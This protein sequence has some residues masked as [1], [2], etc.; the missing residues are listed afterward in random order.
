MEIELDF[1]SSYFS[2]FTI[3]YSPTVVKVTEVK[4]MAS[5]IDQSI[6]NEKEVVPIKMY[7]NTASKEIFK[8]SDED[9]RVS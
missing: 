1:S 5:I 2:D 4:Y 7:E 9:C 6:H 8:V 3:P